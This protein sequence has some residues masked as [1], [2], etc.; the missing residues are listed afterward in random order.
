VSNTNDSGRGSWR[1]YG[2][3]PITGTQFTNVVKVGYGFSTGNWLF[4]L[5]QV[6]FRYI[7]GAYVLMNLIVDTFIGILLFLV[8]A[9]LFH[10]PETGI[11]SVG[12]VI[13]LITMTVL[14][15]FVARKLYRF[16]RWTG[17]W[18]AN[19][20]RIKIGEVL[21]PPVTKIWGIPQG[22]L[23]W[24]LLILLFAPFFLILLAFTEYSQLRRERNHLWGN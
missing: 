6:S 11:S 21:P 12:T 2:D 13:W 9:L 5:T 7:V 19:E 23:I 24:A 4:R 15:I 17:A 22:R 10:D 8:L 16:Y 20:A 1:R 18:I 3:T 14:V